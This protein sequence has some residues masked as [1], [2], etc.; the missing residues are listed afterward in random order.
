MLLV[1]N[2]FIRNTFFNYFLIVRT[3]ICFLAL[4][5]RSPRG[6]HFISRPIG[7][8]TVVHWVLALCWG[9]GQTWAWQSH[10]P[11]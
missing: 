3:C 5:L 11:V 2:F 9:E 8:R 7:F 4:A 10:R 6:Y 1:L